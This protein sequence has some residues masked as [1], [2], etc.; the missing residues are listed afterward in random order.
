MFQV[1]TY[2]IIFFI[3]NLLCVFVSNR[4]ILSKVPDN[5]WLLRILGYSTAFLGFVFFTS[6]G[7]DPAIIVLGSAEGLNPL[8]WINWVLAAI[9]LGM[10]QSFLSDARS[11]H[12]RSVRTKAA[13][14]AEKNAKDTNNK[15]EKV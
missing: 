10:S 13:K 8:R 11:L 2:T 4:F 9:M 7:F 12:L 5:M 1:L 6:W 15:S 3:I 14:L